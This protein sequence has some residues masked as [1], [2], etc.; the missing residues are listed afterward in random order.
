MTQEERIQEFARRM[1][2]ELQDIQGNTHDSH[3]AVAALVNVFSNF[4]AARWCREEYEEVMRHIFAAMAQDTAEAIEHYEAHR[5]PC[6]VHQPEAAQR[7]REEQ[8]AMGHVVVDSRLSSD[9][10]QW[11]RPE[12]PEDVEELEALDITGKKA[13]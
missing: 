4:V 12:N 11:K 13:N 3:E 7:W 5:G 10:R 1:L 9:H 6:L 2:Q 8:E